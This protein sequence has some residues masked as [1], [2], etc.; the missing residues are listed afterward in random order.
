MEISS[1]WNATERL[2]VIDA[3]IQ[4]FMKRGCPLRELK[5]VC[6]AISAL[7][8]TQIPAKLLEI[9][10]REILRNIDEGAL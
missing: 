7:A 9:N 4:T 6:S 2:T 10:K 1:R 5:L 8:N 3:I